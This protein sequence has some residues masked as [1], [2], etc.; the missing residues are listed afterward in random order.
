MGVVFGN[1]IML[2]GLLKSRPTKLFGFV[3]SEL[4]LTGDGYLTHT[5]TLTPWHT[6]SGGSDGFTKRECPLRRELR[7]RLLT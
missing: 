7:R 1:L 3:N 6:D 4:I 2:M 5:I